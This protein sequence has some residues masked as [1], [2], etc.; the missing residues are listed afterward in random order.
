MDVRA[1]E[2]VT[3]RTG[4]ELIEAATNT[5][6]NLRLSEKAKEFV[7]ASITTLVETEAK[8]HNEAVEKVHL[9]E[10]ASVD[11]LADIIGSAAALEDLNLFTGTK[12]YSTPV[13]V[14][15]GLFRFS[16]GT[17]SSPAPATIEI[18]RSK[19]FPMAPRDRG[20]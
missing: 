8:V 3:A 18:L 12:I 4:T 7:V 9:H 13:A 20:K 2:E 19:E 5:L 1:E 10:A 6:N 14:G 11:T 15:G 17:V 16:H